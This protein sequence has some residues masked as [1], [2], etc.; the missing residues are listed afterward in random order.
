MVVTTRA[1]KTSCVNLGVPDER[2][3]NYLYTDNSQ[4]RYIPESEKPSHSVVF[5]MPTLRR[6]SNIWNAW[7][8]ASLQN[9]T[10]RCCT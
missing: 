9:S 2:I 8:L 5:Q 10:G 1:G 4:V 3:P 7:S 6:Q